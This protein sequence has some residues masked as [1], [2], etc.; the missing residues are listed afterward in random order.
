MTQNNTP[1][2][3]P[4]TIGIIGGGQLGRMMAHEATAMG[5]QVAVLDPT[6]DCPTAQVAH[7]HIV[8]AYDDLE[9]IKQ[10]TELS[11]VVT[12]EFEN[13]DVQAASFIEEQGKLP[14]GTDALAIT[15]HRAR[16]KELLQKLSLP[17]AAC[18][19]VETA[20]ACEEALQTI[21]LP[22]VVKTCRGGYDGKGQF[23]IERP[24]QISEAMEFVEQAH[25]CIVEQW[26]PFDKEISVVFTRGVNGEI[27]F[28]PL[29]E[30][31]HVNHVLHT[32]IAPANVHE[33]LQAKAIQAAQAIAEDMNIIGT[34]AIEMFVVGEDIY[35]N[36]MA[37]RPH[38]SG[39]YSIEACNV[40]QFAQHIR[41]ICRLPLV[42]IHQHENA[43]M[44][45]VLGEHMPRALQ[46]LS[47][48]RESFVHLYGKAEAKAQRKMGHITWLGSDVDTLLKKTVPF[49]E[50][51]Q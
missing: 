5:Y 7:K 42:P 1:I 29:A 38:N 43:C 36:E 17:I 9:A 51:I 32:T 45:N 31:V 28:F 33:D 10:L 4:Q 48:D 44:V 30:N 49:K 35:V 50:D 16:E 40:S 34:F 6:P 27:T 26:I 24:E 46:T 18:A 3:P 12:Y 39:H 37:P 47:N 19:T 8:A 41:A 22:A 20:D 2:L 13:V 25:P 23:K 11:D 14:Q 15:Q 21:P